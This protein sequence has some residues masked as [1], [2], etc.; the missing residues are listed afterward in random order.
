MP[1]LLRLLNGEFSTLLGSY[2]HID[3]IIHAFRG[4]FIVMNVFTPGNVVDYIRVETCMRVMPMMYES[5]SVIIFTL[6]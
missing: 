6:I 5:R 1:C 3:Y 4:L 2:K